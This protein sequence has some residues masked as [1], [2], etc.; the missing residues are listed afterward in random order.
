M[1][2]EFTDKKFKSINHEYMAQKQSQHRLHDPIRT[3]SSGAK[4]S[5]INEKEDQKQ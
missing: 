4:S 3:S 1:T 2:T 5:R